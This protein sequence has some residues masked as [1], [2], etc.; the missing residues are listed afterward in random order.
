MSAEVLVTDHF[1]NEIGRGVFNPISTYRVR[2]LAR[3]YEPEFT[4]AMPGKLSVLIVCLS[5]EAVL[6]PCCV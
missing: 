4:Y 6:S 5:F 3:N 2:I 1:G